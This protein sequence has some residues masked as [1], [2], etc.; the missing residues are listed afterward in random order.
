MNQ[1]HIYEAIGRGK[2]STVYKGRKKKTIEYYAIKSVEKSQKT[3]VLQEVR[4][5]H[6]LDHNNVLKFY[7]WYET[8]AH[9]WL[10]LE[11]CVGGDLLTLL[12]QDTRLPEESIHDFARDLVQALQFLHS[13]GVIYCDLK[14][15]N[16]LLD[17]N[18]RLKLCDFG[19]ARRLSDI[20]KSS[21]QELPQ[22]KRGT[23][24]YM[25]P[26]LF[27]EGSVHS[28]GSDL[29]ALGCVM[30]ECYAGRPPFVSSSFTQLVNSII[31]DPMPPLWGNP[32]HEFEDLVS[33]LL[34][35]D[36]VERI[37]WDEL[38]NHSFWRTK[39]KVLPLPPQPAFENFLRLTSRSSSPE[40][41]PQLSGR[42]TPVEKKAL[43]AKGSGIDRATMRERSQIQAKKVENK[44]AGQESKGAAPFKEKTEGRE[45]GRKLIK[46]SAGHAQPKE[47]DRKLNGGA[48]VVNLLRLSKIV[49][50]NML[51]ETENDTYRQQSK[52]NG[53]SDDTDVTL[54]NHDLELNF[55]EGAESDTTEE[56]DDSGSNAANPIDSAEEKDLQK[57][58][59]KTTHAQPAK[60]ENTKANTGAEEHLPVTPSPSETNGRSENQLM[61]PA[62]IEGKQLDTMRQVAATPPNVGIPRKASQRGTE[63]PKKEPTPAPNP[64]RPSVVLSQS[65]WHPSDLSVRPIMLN[66][67][68]EKVP[69]S[70]FD[71]RMLPVER[72]TSSEFVKM[73]S[74][75]QDAFLNKIMT[76]IH[77]SS[78][79]EKINTLKYLETLCTNIDAANVLIN[80]PVMPLLVKLLRTIKLPALRVQLTS[81]MGLLIRHATLIEE[82]LA[83]S[84]IVAV[85]T[86]TLRDKQ[87]KV[88]RCAMA[89]LGELL[90]YIAT[91]NEGSPRAGGGH[92]NSAK[93]VKSSA[94][95][96]PGTT[97]ALVASIL[98]K[99]EDDVTQHYA[100]K[101]IEN[102]ASQG[103]E[104]AQRFTNNEV[105][106]N[107]CYTFR[108][109]AK[110]E[111]LR[112][113][114]GSC[115]VRLVRFQPTTI[116]VVLEKLTF[117][118]LVGGLA[119]G[120]PREQQVNINLLN[121]ALVG[122]SVISNMSKYLLALLEERSLVPSVVAMLEQ[123]P[124]ILRGKAF[125]CAALLCKINRRWLPSLCNAKLIPAVERLT[126]EK[127]LY[128]L[129]CMEALVQTVVSVV[130]SI[131][132]SINTD[133]IQLASGRRTPGPGSSP[134]RGTLRS[135]LPMFPVV[136][137]LMN[138]PTF[139]NRMV[140]ENVLERLASFLKRLETSSFQGQDEF[141]STLLQIVE[142]LSQQSTT[143]LA[144]PDTFIARVL[145][146][147]AVLYE[148]NTDGDMRFLCLKV[149]FDILVVFLDDISSTNITG[150]HQSSTTASGALRRE[151]LEV[152]VKQHFL[153]MYPILLQ[154]EDPLPMY[155]Q[156]L[157]V[158][159]LDL[160][161]I[162]VEDILQLKLISQFFEFLQS[163]L[164]SIN[165][166]NVRLCLYLASSPKVDSKLLSDL[167]IVSHVGGLL[168]FVHAKGM[169]DFLDPVLSLCRYFLIRNVGDSLEFSSGN[170]TCAT[171]VNAGDR[172]GSAIQDIGDMGQ[173][174]GIFLE[175]CGSREPQVTE[176]AA[177]C[178]ALLLK[179][180]PRSA[181]API[182]STM[183]RFADLLETC[184]QSHAPTLCAKLQSQLLFAISASCKELREAHARNQ[185]LRG[186]PS[187]S[188]L[189]AL[190]N[191]IARLRKSSTAQVAEAAASAAFELQRLP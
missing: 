13:K 155:A 152:I 66:R 171:A 56:E 27:Q 180:A 158:M 64:A 101:T 148:K 14:P 67:R 61:T 78:V 103:G 6:S 55:G 142:V 120:S 182:F 135:S 90:F 125:V 34:V 102:I 188:D 144:H 157:L 45:N 183:G 177:D 161:C 52:A 111:N 136:L 190:E 75:Q 189:A 140:D 173:H 191:A 166:H 123:G 172:T 39:C 160:K 117:K 29:W 179:V 50:T 26:E 105:I 98:R 54:E 99:G 139:R 174:A 22:A 133:I 53:A 18:G 94:W 114:A 131:L 126:K 62:E 2:H 106:D 178:L 145:P 121:M 165:L 110:P 86:D 118:E 153:P 154:D 85:L 146:S 33:R 25:A 141:Q 4:T 83:G 104:W 76:N 41:T 57:V 30:Y 43:D 137:N 38:R 65:L 20:A 10:V 130:P 129:Q 71:S 9:L 187:S 156:K 59:S 164:A 92:D 28:Y 122:S 119:R 149:F 24:C 151:K 82:E 44:H 128:V 112:A 100:L 115:L 68:I 150:D 11:Y 143:L 80:G 72:L 170:G 163:D 95:Q 12:R 32:S 132:E 159:L 70:N 79:N 97:V 109:S 176:A 23:P 167:R 93:D 16:V 184:A 169:Q 19:L 89:T 47:S 107:L 60:V 3:K 138:S 17:E 185:P 48:P 88:R 7:A 40:E 81:V 35:K 77:G 116:P 96:I 51:K 87:D 84:G 168:D 108:A 91:Q 42:S 69:E 1:Y 46:G 8:S 127:D 186:R 147:L 73:E 181:A 162:Q 37:Q 49:K 5:L 36:P 63:E 15:S 21:V 134:A 124:E 31:S 74:E 113:T 175:L 58:S